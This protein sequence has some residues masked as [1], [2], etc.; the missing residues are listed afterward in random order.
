MQAGE[1]ASGDH[2]LAYRCYLAA[3]Q[4]AK[5][6]D[7]FGYRL[8]D[9]YAKMAY[10]R[11]GVEDLDQARAT[12]R[13]AI[14]IEEKL[15][16]GD[17]RAL[18]S[19]LLRL[20]AISDPETAAAL[21]S[22][23]LVYEKEVVDNPLAAPLDFV[24]DYDRAR[25]WTELW[26]LFKDRLANQLQEE[27]YGGFHE[28]LAD[29]GEPLAEARKRKALEPLYDE[30]IRVSVLS[31]DPQYEGLVRWLLAMVHFCTSYGIDE[32][33]D[34]A[35]QVALE[36]AEKNLPP[37]HRYLAFALSDRA[38][39]YTACGRYDLA[40]PLYVRA[41]QVADKC[42]DENKEC[43]DDLDIDV[44]DFYVHQGSYG[45]AIGIYT[46]KHSYLELMNA[47]TMLG[48]F[49]QADSAANLACLQEEN[50]VGVLNKNNSPDHSYTCHTWSFS[51]RAEIYLAEGKLHLAETLLE[52]AL[53]HR[54]SHVVPPSSAV[55]ISNGAVGVHFNSSW[56]DPDRDP[57][58]LAGVARILNDLAI[59][60][61]S[62][63]RYRDAER[64]YQRALGII[65]S[66]PHPDERSVAIVQNN[67]G[68]C[69]SLLH[70]DS[71]LLIS[72]V[73][74]QERKVLGPNHPFIAVS[75]NNLAKGMCDRNAYNATTEEDYREALEIVR[76]SLG[77]EHPYYLVILNN[78]NQYYQESHRAENRSKIGDRYE[79]EEVSEERESLA[80]HLQVTGEMPFVDAANNKGYIDILG[81]EISDYGACSDDI[82]CVAE[83][84][85]YG[86][87]PG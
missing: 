7:P 8:G 65:E 11:W 9:A 62:Q 37:N 51:G 70:G 30:L 60:D 38:A 63:G 33:A 75:L 10:T 82:G 1:N 6:F 21:V 20:A 35:S 56:K 74:E 76:K 71:W 87:D 50:G 72:H 4:E 22:R 68:N 49:H 67:L 39:R 15:F 48:A 45:K 81:F 55:T 40:E 80:E 58:E 43:L 54:K 29:A 42:T 23:A 59:V 83:L 12:Y 85:R 27:P 57:E 46:A 18:A 17:K 19:S 77:T 24:R 36:L 41:L 64:L 32:P 13:R 53:K 2:E 66:C 84:F 79:P 69:N 26:G 31:G 44:A 14:D 25:S 73:I 28:L 3:A 61:S 5:K 78:L 34:R 52:Q 16:C 86:P 47:Y